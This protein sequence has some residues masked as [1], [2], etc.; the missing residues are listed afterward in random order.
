MTNFDYHKKILKILADQGDD[1]AVAKN[2]IVG[3]CHAA[4]CCDCIF[5]GDCNGNTKL[6]WLLD[7]WKPVLND[8]ETNFFRL[9]KNGYIV[10]D[11]DGYLIFTTVPPVREQDP[12]STTNWSF[13]K[14]NGDVF[15]LEMFD[16]VCNLNFVF[17]EASDEKPW[18]FRYNKEIDKIEW[19]DRVGG[20][21]C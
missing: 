21:T 8:D 17:V 9:M 18:H 16:D 5:S 1:F 20:V 12:D 11:S 15:Y 13:D 6:Q 10:R 14:D 2:G 4:S 7:E 19:Q 3:F